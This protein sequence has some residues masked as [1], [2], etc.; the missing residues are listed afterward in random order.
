MSGYGLLSHTEVLGGREE[1]VTG[2][3]ERIKK[4]PVLRCGVTL[5]FHGHSPRPGHPGGKG[6]H[7]HTGFS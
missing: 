1:K 3:P 5:S 2:P 4:P 6:R 7:R